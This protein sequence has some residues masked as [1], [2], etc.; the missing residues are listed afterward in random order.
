MTNRSKAL[1]RGSAVASDSV[2]LVSASLRHHVDMPSSR[3]A[4]SGVALDP[5]A[6][7]TSQPPRLGSG[8]QKNAV[9]KVLLPNLF[10]KVVVCDL[11]DPTQSTPGWKPYLHPGDVRCPAIDSSDDR[12]SDY[13]QCRRSDA[14]PP[15]EGC[16][17]LYPPT[18]LFRR[19]KGHQAPCS[20][21]FH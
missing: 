8:F 13:Q 20:Q 18:R 17:T 3:A 6:T 5:R 16:S 2:M 4:S 12:L 1:S 11:C 15:P 21:V 9:L 10:G 7:W 19:C 14:F